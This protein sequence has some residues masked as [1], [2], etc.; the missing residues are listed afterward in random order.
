MSDPDVHIAAWEA[1]GLIDAPL[2]DRL[3]HA[4]G[5]TSS[6][7]PPADPKPGP[8]SALFGPRVT[9][10]EMFAYLGVA[11]LLAAWLA[12]IARFAQT[13]DREAIMAGGLTLAAVVMLGLGV[14]LAR[15]DPRRRRG[16]GIAFITV[17]TLA[18]AAAAFVVQLD[19][20]RNTIQGQG[21][22][23]I[24][25]SGV[26]VV[27]ASTLRR[28]LPAVSTQV[29]LLGALTALAVAVLSWIQ[30]LVFPVDLGSAP[31]TN[32]SSPTPEP[33]GLVLAA[34]GW[35]LLVALGL[36]ILG[37]VEARSGKADAAV[38]RRVDLTRLWAGLVAV[39]GLATALTQSGYRAD[40]NY[41]RVLEP[42]IADVLILALTAVLVE[43][44]V[45]RGSNAFILSAA[46]GLIIALT[47]FNFTYLSQSTDVGLL[48]EGAMLL[49][50]GV[51]GDRL[52]RRLDRSGGQRSPSVAD[53]SVRSEVPPA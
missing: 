14:V 32:P 42:W 5:G 18:A 31:T 53:D 52:R 25:I 30:A 44:A 51:A 27:V 37:M 35:W 40:G 45:R 48:I 13:A 6:V 49:T 21:S 12:F 16:A 50:V 15:G 22:T 38:A 39:G 36:G 24:A 20:L 46:I 17:T 4:V 41:G 19:V 47:D 2:A 28:R 8:A 10:G 7:A 26:A 33:V 29:G 11:F 3:R 9:I 23:G 43:R 1:A 34:G